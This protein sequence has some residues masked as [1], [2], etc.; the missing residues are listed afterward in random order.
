[1]QRQTLVV[2]HFLSYCFHPCHFFR[3][4]TLKYFH[5]DHDRNFSSVPLPCLVLCLSH[6]SSVLLLVTLPFR[7][8]PLPIARNYC[9]FRMFVPVFFLLISYGPFPTDR[10]LPFPLHPFDVI[11]FDC[12][13]LINLVWDV[14]GLCV[15]FWCAPVYYVQHVTFEVK[16]S[17]DSDSRRN[18]GNGC[19]STRTA[20]LLSTL[21]REDCNASNGCQH[22]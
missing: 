22:F 17:R 20:S 2:S 9:F 15:S 19:L 21:N 16:W 4:C 6:L 12:C 5:D 18:A 1:M 14:S 11:F 13:D 8:F 3:Y 7:Y 10:E